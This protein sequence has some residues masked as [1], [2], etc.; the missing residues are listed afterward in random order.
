MRIVLVHPDNIQ[1][2]LL[3]F[4]LGNAGYAVVPVQTLSRAQQELLTNTQSGLV[5]MEDTMHDHLYRLCSDLRQDRFEGPIIVLAGEPDVEDELL[6]FQAGADDYI[7]SPFDPTVLISRLDSVVRR[8]RG[9]F[10]G[11]HLTGES[12][13][14]QA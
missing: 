10:T 2:D 1:R 13:S 9:S 4:L 11:Q 5:V 14:P 8:F 12:A 7:A 3:K 6:A